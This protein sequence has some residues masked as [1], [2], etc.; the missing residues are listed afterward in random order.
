MR[1]VLTVLPAGLLNAHAAGATGA[2]MPG[3]V[4]G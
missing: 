4:C 3:T 2:A 1:K